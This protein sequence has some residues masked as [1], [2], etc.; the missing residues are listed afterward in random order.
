[1]IKNYFKIAFR[2]MIK[3]KAYSAINILGLAIGI[4]CCFLISLYVIDE[5]RFEQCH[6]NKDQ[7]YRV[8]TELNYG[9]EIMH[10]AASMR[11]LTPIMAEEFPEVLNAARIAKSPDVFIEY[12][13]TRF[14][15][16]GF[17]FADS[18]VFDIFTFPLLRGDPKTVLKDPFSMVITEKI[19]RKYFGYDNPIGKVLLYDNQ[20]DFRVTGILAE[21]PSQTQLRC[22]FMASY[23]TKNEIEERAHDWGEAGDTYGYILLAENSNPTMVEQKIPD[24]LKKHAPPMIADIFIHHLQPLKEIYL[25]S[26]LMGEFEPKGDINRVYLFSAIAVLILLIACINF[27]NL[28]T[29]RS[30]HRAREVGM[31]KTL[32]ARQSQLIGQFLG[33]SITISFIAVL[34]AIVF[35]ELTLPY[36]SDFI[37]K[38][39]SAEYAYNL[40][41]IPAFIGIALLVGLI[42]GS[43][44]AFFLSRFQ[45]VSTLKG[46]LSSGSSRSLFRKLLVIFQFT[47]SIA[48]IIAT[49]VIFNQLAYTK[50]KD[51]GFDKEHVVLLSLENPV[52]RQQYEPLKQELLRNPNVINASCTFMA[53]S[54]QRLMKA[55]VKAEGIADEDIPVMVLVAADY[56]YAKTLGL[57][58]V[59]GRD[60]SE[61]FST[62]STA[63]ILNQAAVKAI[64]W[65]DP[66]GKRFSLR[67]H[68]PTLNL[69]GRVIGVVKDFHVQSL[70]E[71]IE[72]LFISIDPEM[73]RT[74]AVRIQPGDI[75]GT[76]GA[77]AQTW[78]KYAA[79][80]IPFEYS[81]I[82]EGF[83]ELYRTEE[84]LSQM[85]TAFSLLAVFIAC[86]G[87]LGL[88]AFA[89]EQRTKE[90]GIRKVMGATIPNIIRLLSTEFVKL[91]LIANAI[92][93]PVAYFGMKRWLQDFAYHIDMNFAI[94]LLAGILVFVIALLT[95]SFQAIKVAIANPVDALK[96]E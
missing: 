78:K 17:L 28:T 87:L 47:I 66:I 73:Y 60:F 71:Q 22:D 80:N 36:F 35:V 67:H 12:D 30:L 33:E 29:A 44:P 5:L 49:V 16:K 7:I 39:L 93:W 55:G 65:D 92:A 25:H 69:E 96:Y 21:V 42:S 4:S 20:H 8:A 32:G 79:N 11:P 54:S 62:D 27:M 2:N 48:L 64:G 3:Y 26:N 40:W 56:D 10:L 24:L 57:E 6:D 9:G 88:A 51:L 70:H 34:F 18:T 89:A 31:R 59:A 43:Y 41:L 90:I 19:A 95:V 1:M 84:R 14:Q 61:D 75:A 83:E 94:F 72:P 15:E 81:F 77:L 68:G 91:V 74:L 52:V 23:Q 86:L 37:E 58:I 82:D 13:K 76:L 45:P 53:P 85:F 50:N 63:Y 38:E 46:K